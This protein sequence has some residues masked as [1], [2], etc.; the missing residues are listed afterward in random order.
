MTV[1]DQ[2]GKFV[3]QF[4]RD[5]RNGILWIRMGYIST[6]GLKWLAGQK[7]QHREIRIAV[8]D[9]DPKYF[10]KCNKEEAL[11]AQQALTRNNLHV[12]LFEG[13]GSK[14][15][16]VEHTGNPPAALVGSANLTKG[17]LI[18]SDV[19]VITTNQKDAYWLLQ[20]AQLSWSDPGGTDAKP[21]ILGHLERHIQQM[22]EGR[23]FYQEE[24]EEPF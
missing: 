12:R 21:V 18:N 2:I 16:V 15:W 8:G 20:K 19:T 7:P 14:D 1:S 10:S 5:N 9:I 23:R 24:E 22:G 3:S 4:L 17:G 6:F 11:A 13:L